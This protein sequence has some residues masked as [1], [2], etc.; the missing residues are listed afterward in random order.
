MRRTSA[1]FLVPDGVATYGRRARQRLASW[2]VV[3]TLRI[4]LA[5]EDTWA[6][7][8]RHKIVRTQEAVR[9]RALDGPLAIVNH[10]KAARNDEGGGEENYPRLRLL[11]YV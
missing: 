9:K 10:H 8:D 2:G 5:V 3:E 7:S 11:V 4:S 1:T 6:R